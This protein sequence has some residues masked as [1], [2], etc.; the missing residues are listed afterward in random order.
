MAVFYVSTVFLS[1][2]LSWMRE[3]MK[4]G[5][6]DVI[7][8]YEI[9]GQ[10]I[11][12]KNASKIIAPKVQPLIDDYQRVLSI[13]EWEFLHGGVNVTVE[14]LN[15]KDSWPYYIKT[16]ATFSQSPE[17]VAKMFSWEQFAKTQKFIDPFFDDAVEVFRSSKGIRVVKK[18]RT[19]RLP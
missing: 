10:C 15:R 4:V 9:T 18:V 6:S 19:L 11:A 5:Q 3:N 17:A 8:D 13:G 1:Y 16:V 2:K 14:C 12:E 7:Y